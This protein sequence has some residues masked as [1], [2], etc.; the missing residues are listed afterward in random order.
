M[1]RPPEQADK[2]NPGKPAL[3]TRRNDEDA[4]AV[5]V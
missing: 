1:L 5:T 2:V 3:D 4:T